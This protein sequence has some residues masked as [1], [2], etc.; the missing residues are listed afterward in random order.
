MRHDD[1]GTVRELVS[2]ATPGK[3]NPLDRRLA[4]HVDLSQKIVHGV[5][6]DAQDQDRIYRLLENN[7]TN[8]TR[9]DEKL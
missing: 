6:W 4:D 1:G 3:H 8:I 5:P 9:L 7:E 2:I